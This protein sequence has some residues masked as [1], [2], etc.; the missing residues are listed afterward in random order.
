MF[1]FMLVTLKLLLL[2]RELFAASC[3]SPIHMADDAL[4][5]GDNVLPTQTSLTEVATGDQCLP[6]IRGEAGALQIAPRDITYQGNFCGCV[7]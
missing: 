7:M 3:D 2:Q 1:H 6:S 5:T 4:A